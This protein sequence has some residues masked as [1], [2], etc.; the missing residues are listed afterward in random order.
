VTVIAAVVLG[1]AAASS[2]SASPSGQAMPIGNLPGWHQVLADDFAGTTLSGSWNADRGQ[3]GGDPAGWWDPSHVTVGDGLLTLRTYPDP[4][5]CVLLWGCTAINDEVSGGLKS[6]LAQVYGKYLVRFRMDRG[7]GVALAALLRPADDSWPP[8]IDFAEDNGA[9]P[10][11]TDYATLHYG[12]ADTQ[13]TDAVDVNLSQWHTLG[14][15]WTRG[16]LVYTLDGR[17]WATV[18]DGGVP[19]SPMRLAV[20][21]QA[22]GGGDSWEQS[23]NGGT[24]AEVDMQVDWIV[25]YSPA[26]S[27]ASAISRARTRS[28]RSSAMKWPQSR[29]GSNR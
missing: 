14:V 25:A 9:D 7:A 27:P 18:R 4:T 28:G 19:S 12:A 2:A 26:T 3:P 15:V 5:A 29:T 13:I 6:T 1:L 24:P 16:E 8:E 17:D 22:W 21:T 10:P 20:Q 23:V 11:T